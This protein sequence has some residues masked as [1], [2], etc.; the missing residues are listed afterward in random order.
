MRASPWLMTVK[1]AGQK[2]NFTLNP[3]AASSLV[4]VRADWASHSWRQARAA[5][6]RRQAAGLPP[7]GRPA[8]GPGSADPGRGRC[9]QV[10]G[11]VKV[12]W[13]AD[14]L[15]EPQAGPFLAMPALLCR[16]QG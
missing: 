2:V 6:S 13:D 9:R 11:E 16:H 4:L 7:R 10:L 3:L 8:P 5:V 1:L 15:G 14:L 12:G